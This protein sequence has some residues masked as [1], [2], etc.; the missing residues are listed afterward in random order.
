MAVVP[1]SERDVK[2]LF[3]KVPFLCRIESGNVKSDQVLPENACHFDKPG[4]CKENAMA[5]VGYKD[6]LIEHLQHSLHLDEPFR[7]F[8]LDGI[9]LCHRH[10]ASLKWRVEGRVSCF[11]LGAHRP[12]CP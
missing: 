11:G 5:V 6:P 4:V 7:F 3:Q 1:I 8:H 10:L 9:S 2:L 12:S